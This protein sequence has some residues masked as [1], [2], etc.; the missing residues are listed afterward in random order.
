M[1][2]NV[3]EI[4]RKVSPA[5]RKK[6]K[7]R[8]AEIIAHSDRPHARPTL[9]LEALSGSGLEVKDSAAVGDFAADICEAAG[10]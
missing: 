7:D 4:I 5:E 10:T 3:N 2:V 9:R 6:V 1:P 8:T